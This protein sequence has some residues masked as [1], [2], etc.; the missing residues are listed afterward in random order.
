MLQDKPLSGCPAKTYLARFGTPTAQAQY[1]TLIAE[2]LSRGRTLPPADDAELSVNELVLAYLRQHV[3]VHYRK[4]GRPTSE[5]HCIDVTGKL[6]IFLSA[7]SLG[8]LRLARQR[9]AAVFERS[10]AG[11]YLEGAR[12]G[13]LVGIAAGQGDLGHGASCFLQR[14]RSDR[15]SC[16]RNDW[17]RGESEESF[18]EPGHSLRRHAGFSCQQRRR[19][20]S[21]GIVLQFADG[22]G[23][24]AMA[25]SLN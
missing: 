13:A 11:G 10:L 21:G 7:I 1:D 5:Q 4:N 2:W 22:G 20:W 12:E 16:L 14:A 19:H 9:L 25:A 24:S 15:Q 17:Q 23:P 3:Q 8:S 18:R 6:W